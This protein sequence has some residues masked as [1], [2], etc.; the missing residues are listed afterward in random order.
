MK[1]S[2]TTLVTLDAI[3]FDINTRANR[4]ALLDEV[5]L[6]ASHSD[7]RLSASLP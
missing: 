4:I 3:M 2:W 7:K 1:G 6:S 5:R